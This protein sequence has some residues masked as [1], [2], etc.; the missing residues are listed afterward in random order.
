MGNGGE[1]VSKLIR[2][3]LGGGECGPVYLYTQPFLFQK[4]LHYKV[5]SNNN[6]MITIIEV[7]MV[8]NNIIFV[9]DQKLGGNDLISVNVLFML[10]TDLCSLM[11]VSLSVW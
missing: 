6:I 1:I 10:K 4:H 11:K 9:D 3:L 8:E 7:P 5:I 2:V